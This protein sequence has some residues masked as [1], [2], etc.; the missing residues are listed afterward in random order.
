MQTVASNE[1]NM[2]DATKN[3]K[4]R[5]DKIDQIHEANKICIRQ[6]HANRYGLTDDN[7]T[8]ISTADPKKQRLYLNI[9]FFF[10]NLCFIGRN[11][12]PI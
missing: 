10:Y 11:W 8:A 6:K 12:S 7:I 4:E 5:K 1:H 3:D 9:L 2:R